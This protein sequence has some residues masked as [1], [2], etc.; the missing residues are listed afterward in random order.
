MK[1]TT[2]D[3][4]TLN[5]PDG[6]DLASNY[7]LH[8]LGE[9]YFRGWVESTGLQCE[10]WGI[11]MRNDTG[12]AIKDDKMDLRLW[13]PRDG[14]AGTPPIPDSFTGDLV[15]QE[16]YDGDTVT[17]T[18]QWKLRGVVDVKTK[19]N[20]DWLCGFNVRHFADYARWAD[21]YNVPV[22]LYFTH[23]DTDEDEVGSPSIL[24]PVT[25]DWDYERVIE[26]FERGNGHTLEWGELKTLV[27]EATI[28]DRVSRAPDGNPVVWI[29]EEWQHDF[30]WFETVLF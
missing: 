8:D 12:A 22:V 27:S 17:H 13:E 1:R 29:A 16:C 9:A 25:T 3:P 20:M 4:E 30:E 23:V 19:G 2:I 28:A 26:H 24:T 15:S 11:D 18:K 10:H 6:N 14:A 7:S 21:H 5:R